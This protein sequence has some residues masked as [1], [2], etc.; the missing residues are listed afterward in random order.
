M[1]TVGDVVVVADPDSRSLVGLE[2]RT[3]RL[4]WTTP[5]RDAYWVHGGPTDGRHLV[6]VDYVGMHS[7]DTATGQVLWTV[8]FPPG[9][10]PR[11]VTLTGL[12]GDIIR[13]TGRATS[14]WR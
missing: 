7:L 11:Y 8:R 12:R 14:V 2:S 1:T 10:D 5:W 9:V 4:I 3:G 13:S 6:F